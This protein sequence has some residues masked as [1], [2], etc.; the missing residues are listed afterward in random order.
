MNAI[1]ST[2]LPLPGRRQGKVR[3]TYSLPGSGGEPDRIVIVATDRISAFDVVLPTPIP[4]KGRLL[5]DISRR[6]FEFIER[7]GLVKTFLLS[8][9]ASDVPGLS[10]E[11]RATIE[12]RVS[13]G[14]LCR[15]APVECVARGYL[16]GSG[17]VEYQRQGTVC[18]VGLPAGL[19]EGDQL[20]EPIFT[21]ATKAEQGEHDE[22]ISFERAC[23]IVGEAAMTRLRDLTLAMYSA[24][25]EYARERGVIIAD[26][27]FEFGY[28][29]G[30]GDD[31]GS[32]MLIDEALTPDSS[33][34]WPVESWR[35]GQE[36]PSFD[37][38]YVRDYLLGLVRQGK[39]DKTAPGPEI[40]AEVVRDTLKRYE[41]AFERLFG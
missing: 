21:P 20:P 39:W 6:W 19:R 1:Y 11:Q 23:E 26:T 2:E 41:E 15:V 28:P 27:K 14:R 24:A 31:P 33:R 3:D 17:W 12:G 38:Q 22:N 25:A 32:L 16:A 18:G 4:G 9:E 34:F 36:Q 30:G 29:A 13:I 37:K 8:T 10:A 7:R 35:P 5:T 40:P